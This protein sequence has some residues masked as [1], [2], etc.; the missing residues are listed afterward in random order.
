[1]CQTAVRG[2]SYMVRDESTITTAA[3]EF[4]SQQIIRFKRKRCDAP[5]DTLILSAPAL[6][7][8]FKRAPLGSIILVVNECNARAGPPPPKRAVRELTQTLGALSTENVLPDPPPALPM[9]PPVRI[10]SAC[11]AVVLCF[12]T[13]LYMLRD[14]PRNHRRNR[15]RASY[16]ASRALRAPRTGESLPLARLL[17]T[18]SGHG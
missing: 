1:M 10:H 16:D 7:G 12:L 15:R 18:W 5:T 9:P 6:D 8:A 14:P 17:G 13:R 2:L 4:L 3:P 11:K